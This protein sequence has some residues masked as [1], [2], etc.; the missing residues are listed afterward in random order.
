MIVKVHPGRIGG[1]L[2]VPASKSMQQR[3]CA[4]ALLN[5]GIT[6][7]FGS[8]K[9]NDE[10]TALEIISKLGA[11]VNNE[12]NVLIIESDGIPVSPDHLSFN[13]SGLS[14]RMFTPI[15]VL[16]SSRIELHGDG[17]L[18]HRNLDGFI[19]ALQQRG[20]QVQ[21]QKSYLPLAVQGPLI[22]NDR[23][24][25]DAADSSQF[26]SGLLMAISLKT[27]QN[28]YIDL[29][30]PVSKPYID[31]TLNMMKEFGHQ[32][33]RTLDFK[34]IIIN[35]FESKLEGDREITIEGDWSHGALLLVIGAL[36]GGI[37]LS[38]LKIN[39]VQAD[40]KIRE[41]LTMVGV[42]VIE[43]NDCLSVN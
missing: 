18:L 1:K 13:E 9:S 42:N 14:L 41:V 5:K 22:F 4:L 29:I 34:Q 8:G 17:S 23:F 36:T 30:N 15:A 10:H 40:R 38:G 20:V 21:G 6:R 26:I 28:V 35:P 7:I 31:L 39:S 37:C 27:T 43:E 11:K 32:V 12:N 24:T 19:H 2:S 25:I 33:E 16:S 3:A